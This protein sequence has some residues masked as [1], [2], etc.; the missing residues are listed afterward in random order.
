MSTARDALWRRRLA[1]VLAVCGDLKNR[2]RDAGA[3][4]TLRSLLNRRL[5]FHRLGMS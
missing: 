4:K 2:R 1:G 5:A 3:T